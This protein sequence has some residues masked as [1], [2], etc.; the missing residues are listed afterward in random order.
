MSSFTTPL[1]IRE[2]GDGTFTLLSEFEYYLNDAW[3]STI[4][5]DNG[6]T[7]DFAT[8]KMFA[9]LFPPYHP[10]YGKAA[11]IHDYLCT[12][13][14]VKSYASNYTPSRK[15]ADEIFLG[16]MKVLNCPAWKRNLMYFGVRFYAKYKAFRQL[17]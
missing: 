11:V 10:D 4:T 13:G 7:T 1:D 2:N 9:W 5:V 14:K 15:R 17:A 12:G 16:C 6:Y 8:T 3:G